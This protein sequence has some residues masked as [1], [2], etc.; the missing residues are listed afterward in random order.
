MSRR[1]HTACCH[2]Y[3]Q[4]AFSL[5]K[6]TLWPSPRARR[7]HHRA[8]FRHE[9]AAGGNV[10]KLVLLI[11]RAHRPRDES[12]S[13][14]STSCTPTTRSTRSSCRTF[15]FMP[16]GSSCCTLGASA[17]TWSS[18]GRV[19][20]ALQPSE[21]CSR[22]HCTHIPLDS[23][24]FLFYRVWC[25][26]VARTPPGASH[27]SVSMGDRVV[28]AS[29]VCSVRNELSQGAPWTTRGAHSIFFRARS[30]H[31]RELGRRQ[32]YFNVFIPA[33]YRSL[34]ARLAAARSAPC[35]RLTR[36]F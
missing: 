13:C 19:A 7:I 26:S 24:I 14:R 3:T 17:P 9:R 2:E 6:L 1:Q 12:P 29:D 5:W 30:S 21:R 33:P 28:R 16:T 10:C 20:H 35:P 36:V 11:S 23:T 34:F 31:C 32:T 25:G 15:A 18:A 27:T 22:T 4:A 8:V